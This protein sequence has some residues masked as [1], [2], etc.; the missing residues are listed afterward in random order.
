MNKPQ[1]IEGRWWIHGNNEPPHF[2]SLAFDPEKGLEL[3]ITI[4][5]N[6][7]GES[8]AWILSDS[9]VKVAHVIHGTDQSNQPVSL[10]G[11]SVVHRSKSLGLDRYLVTVQ[12]AIRNFRAD[13]WENAQFSAVGIRYTLLDQ[14][15]NRELMEKHSEKTNPSSFTLCHYDVLEFEVADGVRAKIQAEHPMSFAHNESNFR[16]E[17]TVYFIFN[18]PVQTRT[19]LDEHVMPFRHLLALLTGEQIFVAEITV[20]NRDPF[21]SGGNEHFQSSE[22]L[23]A[24]RGIMEAKSDV[25]C[26]H[27]VTNYQ[28]VSADFGAMVKLWFQ[29]HQRLAPVLDLY[30]GVLS[31]WVLPEHS[32]FLFVAQALESYHARNAANDS[33]KQQRNKD[34]R[35]RVDRI[36]SVANIEADDRTW[37]EEKLRS[38]NYTTL[39]ERIT[40]IL[41]LHPAEAA[42]LTSAIPEFAAK[43][44]NTRNYYTHYTEELLTKG[45]VAT[46]LE[47]RRILFALRDLLQ[48]CLLKELGIKGKPIERIVKNNALVE[49]GDLRIPSL[50]ATSVAPPPVDESV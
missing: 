33:S 12:V 23:H 46:G 36:L 9:D 14:W 16:L 17:H 39:A 6:R 43:V 38:S 30:F 26:M 40:D 20:F 29:C 34:F 41:K 27:M 13:S 44:K 50:Q 3:S 37:L 7:D 42:S 15:M 1:T 48:I 21:T 4:L 11:C 22:L 28:E 25:H 35:V 45:K 19:I 32:Q 49:W 10:F 18:G 24:N 47:L 31:D 5:P 8:I 2:G